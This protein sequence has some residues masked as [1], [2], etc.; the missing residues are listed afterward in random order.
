M[1]ILAL[2]TAVVVSFGSPTKIAT[3]KNPDI[4]ESSG[5]AASRLNPNIYW[6][7]NDSGDGPFV[8]AFDAT[9]ESRA[10][11]R[12]AGAQ[13]RDW[14]D[15]AIGPGPKP[16]ESYL[17]IGDIGDNPKTQQQIVVYRVS[18]PK[19][20]AADKASSKRN[21]KTTAPA[22]AIRLRYPDGKNDAE[23]LLV[24][25]TTGNLYVITKVGFRNASVYEAKAPL[26]T[27]QVI[28]MNRLGEI[29]IP[30][31]LG[32]IFTGGS[33]SPDG[34]RV[35]LCDYL[36]GYEFVLSAASKNFN[37]IWKQNASVFNLGQRDQGESITYRADG[38][39]ILA[40]TEGK[41][42]PLIQVLLRLSSS[43]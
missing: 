30:S 27:D 13:A 37:D 40:T 20:T 7:H 35:V 8:Y 31:L 39:A 9:G 43:Q 36:Q 26:K 6:T 1:N 3:L 22:E 24:H 21:P 15:M 23:T 41:Q 33:I 38:K 12:V 32:G 42:P 10:V 5:L 4:T 28:T 18:E 14:E 2:I 34:R 25:P 19:L 16:G 11:F 17:Y 29:K